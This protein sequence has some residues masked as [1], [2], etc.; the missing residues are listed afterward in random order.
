MTP[1]DH[2]SM[3]YSPVGSGAH[4]VCGKPI[5]PD[6]S[7]TYRAKT[8]ALALHPCEVCK[9]AAERDMAEAEPKAPSA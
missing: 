1:T 7:W 5:G 8:A 2:E 9:V 3:H 4:A 6:V